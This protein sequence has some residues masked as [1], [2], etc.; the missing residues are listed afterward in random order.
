MKQEH[1]VAK[2][3]QVDLKQLDVIYVPDRDGVLAPVTTLL[4]DD[5]PWISSALSRRSKASNAT[6]SNLFRFVHNEVSLADAK[7]LGA[8]SLREQLFA[9][10]SAQCFATTSSLRLRTSHTASSY[11]I[12]LCLIESMYR[13]R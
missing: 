7:L 13:Y 2:A 5:A 3:E 8:K 9:G 12:N 11:F 1:T 6:Q 4:Y 10:N